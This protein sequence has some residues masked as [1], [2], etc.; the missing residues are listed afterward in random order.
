MGYGSGRSGTT[1]Y[2]L[3]SNS[4]W[5]LHAADTGVGGGGLDLQDAGKTPSELQAPTGRV[6]IYA[7]WRAT[8]WDFGNSSQ[9]PALKA[10]LN[11]DGTPTA[12]EFGGQGRTAPPLPPG[13][14]T[15]GSVT[16]G[17][18]SLTVSWRE[19]SSGTADITAYDLRHIRAS[20]DQGVD[21]NWTV[22]DDAWTAGSGPLQYVLVGLTNGTQ[23]GVQVRAVNSVGDGPWSATATGTPALA[24]TG[25]SATRSFSVSSVV[26]G[27]QV[28]VTIR[29][30][31]YG[32]LGI[33]TETL[34]AGFSYV[35]SS[36][37]SVNHPVDGDSQKVRF[38]LLGHTS[39]TYAVTA[40]RV[41]GAHGFSGTLTDSVGNVLT[42][43]GDTT[44]TVDTTATVGGAPPGVSVSRTGTS[45]V[46]I[47]T[48]IP[49]VAT[50]TK[51][52]TGFT[53][54]TSS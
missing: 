28:T 52:V 8:D 39:F 38:T 29:A 42:V 15:I 53:V 25:A 13:A 2:T 21:A 23:Y 1:H 22:V 3:V 33:V 10:D 45:L 20:A 36:H 54:A 17:A 31:N 41:G 51:P 18:A 6:G 46:R 50:F 9:Y 27:G 12:A 7:R 43:G 32:A 30:A 49:V 48:A 5:N 24:A 34:P 4:Y 40:S 44:V 11:G 37:D 16:P 26:P 19:P 35:S 47:G 14:V